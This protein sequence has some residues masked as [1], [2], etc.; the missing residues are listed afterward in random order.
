MRHL[1]SSI[2]PTAVA[3]GVLGPLIG[4]V[5]VRGAALVPLAST[6]FTSE[7][8]LANA[9]AIVFD[10]AMKAYMVGGFAAAI[11]GVWV[12]VFSPFALRKLQFHLGVA[13]IG[14]MNAWLFLFSDS[15]GAILPSGPIIAVIG[16]VSSAACARLFTN[17]PLQRGEDGRRSR[18]DRMARARAERLAK[19][20]AAA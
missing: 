10:A 8:Q 4:L 18:R 12:A 20:R 13:T 7:S 16:A 6:A 17:W 5:L 3:F 11:T 9:G 15:A 19:A 1:A 2:A 14:G